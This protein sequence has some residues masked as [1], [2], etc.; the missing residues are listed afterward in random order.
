VAAFFVPLA[1]A[2]AAAMAVPAD[3]VARAGATLGG[4]A[5]GALAMRGLYRLS[6]AGRADR[7]ESKG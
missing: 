4:L 1:T 3:G 5:A 7:D 2:I 6:R